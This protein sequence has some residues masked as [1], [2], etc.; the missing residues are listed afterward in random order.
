M[1]SQTHARQ[2]REMQPGPA[3]TPPPAAAN[4]YET[5]PVAPVTLPSG[6]SVLLVVRWDDVRAALV[7]PATS[8]RFRKGDPVMAPGETVETVPNTIIN[9]DPPEHTRLRR[10]VAGAL[11]PRQVET[12]RPEIRR[13]ATDV[14]A[15]LGS[16]FDV[17][18]DYALALSTRAICQVVGTPAEDYER[19]RTWSRDLLT[20][21]TAGMQEREEALQSLMHYMATLVAQHR[22][23]PGQDL[24]DLLIAARDQHDRLT[25][26]ELVSMLFTLIVAGHDTLI[27][28]ISRAV[29]RLLHVGCYA[30]LAADPSL[31]ASAVEEVLRFDAPGNPGLLRRATADIALPSGQVIPAGATFQPS[32]YLADHDPGKFPEPGQFDLHRSNIRDHLAF[33]YGPHY[34]LGANLARMELQEALSALVTRLPELR[35]AIALDEV[36][37]TDDSLSYRPL[38]LHVTG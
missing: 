24:I 21:S 18:E 26:E 19:F 23:H 34:C 30:H 29:F 16:S 5:A 15:G 28:M 12:W 3:A 36:L 32:Q 10:I 27:T 4:R 37:W 31:V 14:L 38:H 13:I 20:T 33:G 2:W 9:M 7:C 35:P 8:R 11:S 6:D 25:E 17:V 1:T 22:A